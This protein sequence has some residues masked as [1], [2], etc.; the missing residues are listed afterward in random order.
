MYEEGVDEY[1]DAKRKVARRFGA[2]KAFS[3]GSHLP[4]NAEIHGELQRLIGLYE[5][6]LLPERLLRLRS[7]ALRLMVPRL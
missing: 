6:E 1:R 3:L 7:I 5:K 4:S 2:E